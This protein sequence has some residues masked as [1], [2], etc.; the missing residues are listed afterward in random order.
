MFLD[1]KIDAATFCSC[2]L[3]SSLSKDHRNFRVAIKISKNSWRKANV[4]AA[5]NA[6]LQRIRRYSSPGDRLIAFLDDFCIDSPIPHA[7]K[8]MCYQVVKVGS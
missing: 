6:I 4:A 3:F 1:N 2:T 5:E 7:Q 8:R